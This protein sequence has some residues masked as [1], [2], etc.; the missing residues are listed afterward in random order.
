MSWQL[1]VVI[2]LAAIGLVLLVVAR[3]RHAREVFD[4][5]TRLDRPAEDSQ[6]S[7]DEL[8]QARARRLDPGFREEQS[9]HRRQH[10]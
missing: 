3:M 4:N 1:W 5:I 2:A 7:A 6:L 10:G 8:T 9:D